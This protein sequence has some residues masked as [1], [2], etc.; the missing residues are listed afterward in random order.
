M[1]FFINE[2]IKK[3]DDIYEKVLILNDII[4]N[5]EEYNISSY[6]EKYKKYQVLQEQITILRPQFLDELR[7]LTGRLLVERP[8]MT[9]KHIGIINKEVDQINISK[10]NSMI[11]KTFN[12]YFNCDEIYMKSMDNIDIKLYK[13]VSF[14]LKKRKEL[15][16]IMDEYKSIDNIK[17]KLQELYQKHIDGCDGF[18]TSV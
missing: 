7:L 17:F 2:E 18:I 14:N 8:T 3:L 11:N 13:I 5:T 4:K 6:M 1:D 15:K 9:E 16:M 12:K 10:D